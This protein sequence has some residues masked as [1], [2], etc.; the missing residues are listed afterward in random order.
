VSDR[1]SHAGRVIHIAITSQHL[2]APIDHR[3][4]VCADCWRT[5]KVALRD[6]FRFE[7][8][9]PADSDRVAP[10][11]KAAAEALDKEERGW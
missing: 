3:A 2:G 5:V 11:T 7:P 4:E 9:V 1:T 10:E 8:P 6:L